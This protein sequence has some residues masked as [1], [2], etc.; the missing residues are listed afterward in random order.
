MSSTDCYYFNTESLGYSG[1]RVKSKQPLNSSAGLD[2]FMDIPQ[3]ELTCSVSFSCLC[4]YSD[5]E[6]RIKGVRFA[7]LF[8]WMGNILNPVTAIQDAVLCKVGVGSFLVHTDY[9][10]VFGCTHICF[11]DQNIIEISLTEVIWF[12]MT[13]SVWIILGAIHINFFFLI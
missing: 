3:S 6:F 12:Y 4:N 1:G 5:Q 10:F 13:K 8:W 7:T 11:W 2:R 9:N